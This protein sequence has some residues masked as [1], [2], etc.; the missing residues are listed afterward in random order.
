MN[1]KT[2]PAPLEDVLRLARV[3][4]DEDDWVELSQRGRERDYCRHCSWT[5]PSHAPTCVVLAASDMLTGYEAP[6]GFLK[7]GEPTDQGDRP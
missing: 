1:E 4:S 3:I 5:K 2:H 7:R 6:G